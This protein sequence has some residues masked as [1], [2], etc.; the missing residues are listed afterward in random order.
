MLK[1]LN[2]S[3]VLNNTTYFQC[4]QKHKNVLSKATVLFKST[5]NL[6]LGS[7]V[8]KKTGFFKYLSVDRVSTKQF[9]SLHLQKFTPCQCFHSVHHLSCTLTCKISLLAEKRT[10]ERLLIWTFGKFWLCNLVWRLSFELYIYIFFMHNL[11]WA[12]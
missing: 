3:S 12:V 1:F 8:T 2:N 7:W 11:H 9:I 4:A 6:I 10:N 5:E